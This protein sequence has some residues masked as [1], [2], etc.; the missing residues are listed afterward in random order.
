MI[1]LDTH[2]WVWF[3]SNPELLSKKAERTIERAV[4]DKNVF[5]SSI[6]AWEVALLTSKK[7]LLLSMEVADWIKKSEM[8]PFVN[9]IPV[10]NSIAVKSVNLPQ[11]FHSDPADRIIIATAIS[12]GASLITKDERIL[13]Y[14]HVKTIW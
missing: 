2:A 6:S 12:L 5:I 4:V 14:P 10:D 9:F 13:K 11:P 1:V 8:L 3:V 7:R